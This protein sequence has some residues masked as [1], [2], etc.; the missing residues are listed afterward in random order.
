MGDEQASEEWAACTQDCL[1]DR[2][3]LVVSS[4][5]GHIC[6]ILVRP[7]MLQDLWSACCKICGGEENSFVH[8][9]WT[10]G[11]GG[12]LGGLWLELCDN[13]SSIGKTTV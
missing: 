3:L 2:Y 1:V 9:C 6:E 7:E 12:M 5:Q 10:T 4:Y 8:G 13:T 11:S